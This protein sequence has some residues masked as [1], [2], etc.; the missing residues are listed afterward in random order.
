MASTTN[1]KGQPKEKVTP[2]FTAD[3]LDI[4]YDYMLEN[5]DVARGKGKSGKKLTKKI[6]DRHWDTLMSKLQKTPNLEKTLDQVKKVITAYP[7]YFMHVSTAYSRSLVK[8]PQAQSPVPVEEKTTDGDIVIYRQESETF[9]SDVAQ[10]KAD[11]D[12]IDLDEYYFGRDF[13]FKFEQPDNVVETKPKLAI[14]DTIIL[15]DDDVEISVPPAA[16]SIDPKKEEQTICE[17]KGK[18][19]AINQDP[20]TSGFV[21][22]KAKKCKS[23]GFERTK[24]NLA[25]VVDRKKNKEATDKKTEKCHNKTIGEK[26]ASRL[27]V[28]KALQNAEEEMS[29]RTIG[30]A[31]QSNDALAD[32]AAVLRAILKQMQENAANA[33]LQEKVS[34]TLCEKVTSAVLDLCT[35]INSILSAIHQPMQANRD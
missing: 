32:I 26:I 35:A 7:E 34:N 1:K 25:P 15:S 3:Q 30:V 2:A 20:N 4:V 12:I 23:D 17:V 31:E 28:Y 5:P 21:R 6:E 33:A 29:N 16:T 10:K 19:P 18:R 22:P 9:K 14:L 8:K 24:E 11:T 27:A 13:S